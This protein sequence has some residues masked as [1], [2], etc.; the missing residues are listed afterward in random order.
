[1]NL[2]S[3][4][5]QWCRGVDGR[6][7]PA[8][9]ADAARAFAD[10]DVL[11]LQ[12]VTV[13]FPGLPGNHGEDQLAELARALPGYTALFGAA[14]DLGGASGQRRQFGNAIFTRL[15]VLQA[16]RHLLPW[17]PDPAVPSMQR[18]A[19][20]A[21]VEWEAGRLRV[22]C[23]HLEYY[24]TPQRL[25]Q[26]DGLR[27]LHHEACMHAAHPR[28]AGDAD[29]PFEAAAR[30]TAAILCGDFN[31]RP[32]SAEHAAVT[33]GFEDA[34]TPALLDAWSVAHPGQPHEI[35]AGLYDPAWPEAYCCDFVFVSEDLSQLVEQVEVE[36]RTQASDHQPLLLT[37]TV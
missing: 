26:I 15:P 11:C 16:F 1:V 35:T 8:R 7:D 25:A 27:R 14:T 29:G 37:V 12:E 31:F 22:I 4:N 9:I 36:S 6:V 2:V 3:W 33:A 21:V 34:A 30:P 5:I 24:S 28:P 10:F 23:T 17:P 18:M 19:L 13:N 32:G 20:E